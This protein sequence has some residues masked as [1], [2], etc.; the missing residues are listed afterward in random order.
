MMDIRI[1]RDVF[2]SNAIR[3]RLFVDGS[4]Q[5]FTCENLIKSIPDGKYFLK[6]TFSSRFKRFLPEVYPTSGR[7][8]IRI[9]AGNSF[10]DSQGCILVGQTY[11]GTCVYS[12]C[13]ALARLCSMI[14][15]DKSNIHS[16]TIL[17]N[18]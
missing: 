7:S 2:T 10:K 6:Y 9:H 11:R 14:F 1:V 8:G 4:F 18:E 13:L 15:S 5:C 3:G 16:L 12:S 17:R